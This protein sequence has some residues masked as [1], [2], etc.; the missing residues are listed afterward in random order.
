VVIVGRGGVS[1]THDIPRS[2]HVKLEAPLEWR[3]LRIS[4]KC[5][6]SLDEARKECND[7]DSKRQLFREYFQGK[8][9]DYTRFDISLNCMTLSIEEIVRI[10]IKAVE[11][12]KLI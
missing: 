4:E 12:K 1:I 6:L 8:N 7:I 5:S 10:I 3:A 9:S 2:L 11:V